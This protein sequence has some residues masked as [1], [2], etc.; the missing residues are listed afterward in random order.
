MYGKLQHW[1]HVEIT[2]SQEKVGVAMIFL[3]R[4]QDKIILGTHLHYIVVIDHNS[5][6]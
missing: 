5:S 1:A 6:Q 4:G 2:L 3:S